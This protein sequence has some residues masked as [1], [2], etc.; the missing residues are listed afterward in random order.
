[1]S[2]GTPSANGA[3]VQ[4][5][6]AISYKKTDYDHYHMPEVKTQGGPH[7]HNDE[8]KRQK[9]NEAMMN[10]QSESGDHN[11]ANNQANK[12]SLQAFLLLIALSFHTIF[13]GLAVGLQKDASEVWS[14][15]VAIALHKTIIAFCLGFEMF[16][17]YS[18]KA[19]KALLWMS[20]FSLMSPLGIGLGMLLTSGDIDE[21]A[22]SLASG[23]LQGV[24]AGV[25]LYVTFLEILC[26]YMG[27]SCV[28]GSK[29]I[30]Y[31]CAACGLGV[32]ACVKALDHD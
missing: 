6:S 11:Q 16:K 24:A 19:W 20:M 30:Y 27:H 25:F 31:L 14:V 12:D 18:E 4:S 3:D 9:F 1:M 26:S 17:S 13:D 21:N 8:Q 15:F 32:M 22:K 2:S 29:F 10:S 28:R 7:V 23:I 5:I